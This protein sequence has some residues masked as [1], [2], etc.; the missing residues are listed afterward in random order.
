M[1]FALIAAVASAGFALAQTTTPPSTAPPA[2]TAPSSSTPSAG[3]G[4]LSH[5]CK[6]E[7]KKAC[8]RAHGEEMHNCIKSSLD[9]NKFSEA[10]KTQLKQAAKPSGG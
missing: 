3:K 4:H 7:V 1:S 9:L 10:C 5:A 6:E 2:A 8:G